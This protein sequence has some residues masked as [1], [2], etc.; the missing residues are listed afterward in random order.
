MTKPR[1]TTQVRLDLDELNLLITLVVDRTQIKRPPPT[2]VD[3]RE[4]VD[5]FDSAAQRLQ[6][7]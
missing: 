7:R 5:K 3:L 1:H 2:T 6:E 4:L